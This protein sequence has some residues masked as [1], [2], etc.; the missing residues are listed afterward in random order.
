MFL[1]LVMQSL[2]TFTV[3]DSH[4]PLRVGIISQVRNTA[5]NFSSVVE[6]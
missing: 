5:F 6:V 1:A 4:G 2:L 3:V